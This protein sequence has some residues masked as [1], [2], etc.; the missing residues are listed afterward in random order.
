MAKAYLAQILVVVPLL[1][2]ISPIQ[3]DDAAKGDLWQVTSKMSMEGMPMEMPA[4]TVKV[5]AAKEWKRPPSNPNDRMQCTNQ[6]FQRSGNK[7]TWETTCK[8]PPAMNGVGEMIFEGNDSY[9]GSIKYSGDEGGM[10]I[11]LSGKK[12]GSCDNPS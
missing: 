6:N 11:K 8:G 4:Q 2:V 9:T 12:L 1:L 10:T 5:C 7:A 3:A